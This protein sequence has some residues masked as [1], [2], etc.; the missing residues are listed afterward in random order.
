MCAL[1]GEG[2]RQK[3]VAWLNWKE[4]LWIRNANGAHFSICSKKRTKN[5]WIL[6]I[7]L[8]L[9]LSPPSLCRQ[10]IHHEHLDCQLHIRVSVCVG[11]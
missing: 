8:M 1:V 4:L 7:N 2:E 11:E 5:N 10:F 3:R 6:A 9:S